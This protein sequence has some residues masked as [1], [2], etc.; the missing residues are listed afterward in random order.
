M[1]RSIT[2]QRHEPRGPQRSRGTAAVEFVIAMPVLI[3]LMLAAAEL[4]RV[5][6][7]YDTLSYS[8]RDSARFVTENAIDGTT[9]VVNITGD[10]VTQAR[11]L[12][13]YGNT[14]GAG[15][16][17]LPGFSTGQVSV[18]DAGNGNIEVSAA[19]P[20]QP[21]IGNA[22]P[23]LGGGSTSTLFMLRVSVTM[24]AIS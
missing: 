20:Y 5:F 11:N 7:Q 6:V 23:R 19:Y 16:P 3:V 15:S 22:L 9:G 4:G 18:V 24:R 2:S 12:A 21:M 8:I 13:V 17:A 10:V 14:A 1:S